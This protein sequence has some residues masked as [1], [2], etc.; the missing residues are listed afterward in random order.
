[1]SHRTPSHWLAISE[2]V[3]MTAER[4]ATCVG[5]SWTTSGHGGKYGSR[6]IASTPPA[7]SR[8]AGGCGPQVSLGAPH[9]VLRM[10]LHPIM[11]GRDMIG[12]EVEQKA[13]PTPGQLGPGSCESVGTA[14][15]WINTITA[16]A[17]R[18]ADDVRVGGVGQ[19]LTHL[20]TNRLVTQGDRSAYRAALP[21]AHEPDRVD[22]GQ[23][24]GVPLRR[25]HVG[26][27]DLTTATGRPPR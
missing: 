11:V 19:Q 3:S 20:V 26:E 17:V 5:S 25:G 27:G 6:P 23:G 18:G 8:K 24:D 4:K 21:D 2:R 9:E 10:R 7:V 13:H 12:D 15:L 16:D 14:E 22:P 1:M